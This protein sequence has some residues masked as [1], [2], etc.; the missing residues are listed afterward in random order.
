M[1]ATGMQKHKVRILLIE[2]NPTDVELFRRALV[3]AGLVCDLTVLEDG[4]EAL[5]LLRRSDSEAALPDLVVLDLNLPKHDGVEVLQAMR[6]TTRY[7]AVPVAI[8]SSS[9]SPRERARIEPFQVSRYITKP[10]DLDQ[11]MKIGFTVKEL[12]AGKA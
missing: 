4:A 6:A 12:V 8:L 7:T 11:F 10:P 5:A 2:D 1:N 3:T 9:S